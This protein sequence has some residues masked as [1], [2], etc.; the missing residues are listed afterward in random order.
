MIRRH[1][2]ADD[3]NRWEESAAAMTDA[4][5][6]YAATDCFQ[7]AQNWRG[8]DGMVEG[9]YLDQ[10]CTFADALNRRQNRR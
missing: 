10:G 5:L 3:F 4:Q 8:V 6:H 2:T 9:F 7:T 1:A